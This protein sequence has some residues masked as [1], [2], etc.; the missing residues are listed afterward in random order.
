MLTETALADGVA[1]HTGKLYVA[2]G[3]VRIS[4][5]GTSIDETSGSPATVADLKTLWS[6]TTITTCDYASRV[7]GVF[8]GTP[9]VQSVDIFET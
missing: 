6:A 9:G 8:L 7:G 2:D 4:T 1:V 3:I 5:I